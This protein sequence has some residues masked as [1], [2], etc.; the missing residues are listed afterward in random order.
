MNCLVEDIKRV[1]EALGRQK[2]IL[3]AHDWGGAVAWEFIVRYHEMVDRYIIMDAPYPSAFYELMKTNPKQLI[4][5]LY[6][7]FFH[8][9]YL[10]ELSLSFFDFRVFRRLFRRRSPKTP[11]AVTNED[12]EVFKYNL[13]APEELT[14]PL[15]YYRA[16]L[17]PP[18]KKLEIEVRGLLM[19]GELDD[20]LVL[21][22]VKVAQDYVKN[23]EGRIVKGAKHFVQQ[24][25]PDTVN[26]YMREFLEKH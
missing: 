23:L 5:S 8:L 16:A 18:P 19:L 9:P 25:D 6:M 1:V 4:C 24:G 21:Y 26:R 2:C 14:P 15:N 13:S 3:V 11:F 7:C 12:I 10:P 20:Y 17:L 22:N